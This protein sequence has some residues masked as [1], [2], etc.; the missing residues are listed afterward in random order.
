MYC[1]P[2]DGG[3]VYSDRCVMSDK[4]VGL[5]IETCENDEDF[6]CFLQLKYP[7]LKGDGFVKRIYAAELLGDESKMKY[8]GLRVEGIAAGCRRKNTTEQTNSGSTDPLEA[9]SCYSPDQKELKVNDITCT[10]KGGTVRADAE[11]VAAA[12]MSMPEDNPDIES[13]DFPCND[14][15][16]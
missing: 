13:Y 4:K 5:E 11:E 14:I 7:S 9:M 1:G 2:R 6:E 3:I 10:C 15:F 8:K 16:F 12:E